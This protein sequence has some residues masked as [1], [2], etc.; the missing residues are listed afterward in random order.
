M[1]SIRGH[2]RAAESVLILGEADDPVTACEA[3]LAELRAA[4]IEHD[5]YIHGLSHDLRNALTTIS[6]Q[7]QLLGRYL[8]KGTLDPARVQI[9]VERIDEAV[10]Q[11]NEIIHRLNDT[12]DIYDP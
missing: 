4:V 8:A 12:D 5:Q 2:L 6:G 1:A 7:A 3:A 9:A 10:R 11:M